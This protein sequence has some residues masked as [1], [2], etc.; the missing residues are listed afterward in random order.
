MTDH[1]GF[2]LSFDVEEHHRIEAAVEAGLEVPSAAQTD[3]AA[4]MERCTRELIELLAR[5]NLRATFFVVGEIAATHPDLV[6][7]IARSGHEVASHG[8]RHTSVKRLT[9]DTF[10]D[11]LRAS[12]QALE[13]V[14]QTPVVGFRAPTFSIVRETSWAIDVLAEEGFLYDSSIFPVRH[15]RYGVPYAPR[16]P[17]RALGPGQGG[18]I[19]LPPA[20]VRIGAR[21]F[22]V[23][24]GGY[25]RLIPGPLFRAAVRNARTGAK[26][27]YFHP[28][29]F[30]ETQPRLALPHLSRWRTYVGTTRTRRRLDALLASIATKHFA[31]RACDFA[32]SLDLSTLP[33]HA[34]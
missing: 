7:D 19:E 31:Q 6:R 16:S 23:G 28:W 15:D 10:R 32:Q 27:L 3:Y 1:S 33:T 24:G 29:E 4:R 14:A 8:H 9:P 13:Q 20:T 22:P 30:D 26:V 5:H 21:N 17:F 11:D 18:L 12:K 2:V 34:L 25:F